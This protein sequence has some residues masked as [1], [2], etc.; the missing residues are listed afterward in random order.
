MEI[1]NTKSDEDI[2]SS[3]VAE[4]AKATNE[5]ACGRRD[6]NKATSRL[7]FCLVLA[8]ELERRSKGE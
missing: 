8:N 5:I 1:L 7:S 4:I 2:I 3:I 6:L